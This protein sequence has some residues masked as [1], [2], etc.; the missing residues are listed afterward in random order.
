[1]RRALLILL[2]CILVIAATLWVAALPG[3]VRFEAG[4]LSVD[5]ATPT[6]VFVGLLV[7]LFFYLLVRGLG[8]LIRLPRRV[9]LARAQRR[10]RLGDV[11]VTRTL[12]ALAAENQR[13]ALT[14]SERARKLLGDTPQTLLLAAQAER[15]AKH[16]AEA[17]KIY[18]SLV[19]HPDASLLGLRGLLG[20]AIAREDWTEAEALADRAE[21]AHPN[22]A[23]LRGQRARLVARDGDLPGALRLV[24]PQVA[25]GAETAAASALTDDNAEGLK[26]ARAAFMA[27][28]ALTQA[29]LAYAARLRATGS[30]R[31]ALAVL[32]RGWDARPHPDLAVAALQTIEDAAARETAAKRLT[33]HTRD[34][35]ESQML[36][37]RTALD[38]GDLTAARDAADLVKPLNQQRAWRLVAEV[39][40]RIHPDSAAVRAAWQ[41]AA[42]ADPDPSWRCNACSQRQP[43]WSGKCSHCGRAGTLVWE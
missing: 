35:P 25:T 33:E 24:G 26:L 12:V 21:R 16:D 40:N 1:M 6:L 17:T 34:N 2:A 32:Q 7:L 37:A 19:Q 5:A 18:T 9:R 36:L 8:A 41:R 42:A 23:W 4:S 11:A 31:K 27:D 22:S 39:E 3:A 15:L 13:D 38:A 20:Q 28:P 14:E 10:R 43:R 30:E 29:A